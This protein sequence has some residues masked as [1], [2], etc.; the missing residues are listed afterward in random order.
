MKAVV[1]GGCGFVGSHV[2]DALV[3]RGD[4]VVV[5]DDLATGDLANFNAEAELVLGS[6]LDEALLE[7]VFEG[8]GRVFHLA[9]L[10]RISRSIEDPVGTSQINVLGTLN[11]LEAARMASVER[12]V[13]SSSSSVYGA[14]PTHLMSEDMPSNPLSPYALQKLVGE[15]FAGMYA[16]LYGMTIVSLCYFNVYGPRQP[17]RGPYAL[18][19]GRFLHL[20]RCGRPL[21]IYG[22]GEQTRS[23]CHVSDVVRANLLAADA[24]LPSGK[25]T[26]LNIGSREET[27]VNEIARMVGGEVEYVLPN[28]RGTMEEQR[29][30]ADNS[31]TASILGWIPSVTLSEGIEAL[32][33]AGNGASAIGDTVTLV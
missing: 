29:K 27:S 31:R 10:P 13:Y 12:T 4:R 22:D 6:I 9:A 11:V 23:Y 32:V 20:A 5:I 16:R 18:V 19:I 24:R 7:R 25:N 3:A 14:Q 17:F 28:P 21:T 15:Q 33:A 26:V 30:A 1:T 2:V 8:A